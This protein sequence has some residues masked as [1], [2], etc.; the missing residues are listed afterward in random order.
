V[1][2]S[3]FNFSPAS[4]MVKQGA[5]VTVTNGDSAAQSAERGVSPVRTSDAR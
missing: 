3:N 1:K 4:L 5:G 2:I